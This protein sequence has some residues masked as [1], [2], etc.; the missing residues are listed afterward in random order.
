MLCAEARTVF[1]VSMPYIT[2][3]LTLYIRSVLHSREARMQ[4]TARQS[5]IPLASDSQVG[6]GAKNRAISAGFTR[7]ECHAGGAE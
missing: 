4:H 7:F 5:T 2:R 1:D 3:N 6:S